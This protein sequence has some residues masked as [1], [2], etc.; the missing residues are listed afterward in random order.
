ME[1]Q[2]VL[3][4]D[5]RS[6]MKEIQSLY[7]DDALVVSNNKSRGRTEIIVAIDLAATSNDELGDLHYPAK[8]DVKI[9]KSI[10]N[11]SF[12]D[13]MEDKI[14]KS[15]KLSTPTS[16]V[17]A[18]NISSRDSHPQHLESNHQLDYLRSRE[19]LELVK[20]ELASIREEVRISQRLLRNDALSNISEQ[21]KDIIERLNVTG[22]PLPMRVLLSDMI[23]GHRDQETLIDTLSETIGRSIK[24]SDML[25]NLSGVHII[26]GPVGSGKSTMA[27]RIARQK[28]LDNGSTSV[29]IISFNDE[30]VGAWDQSQLLGLQAGVSIF[31]ARTAEMLKHLV[32]QLSDRELIII[33]TAG[34][35]LESQ[36]SLLQVALPLA[37]VHLLLPAD[38]SQ[39]LT[40]QYMNINSQ[41]WTSVMVSRLEDG[42][43]PWSVA[44]SLMNIDV[45]LSIASASNCPLEPAQPASGYALAAHGFKQ[46]VR[47]F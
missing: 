10:K 28:V 45:P 30:R 43:Y 25:S 29:A 34:S 36:L 13:V 26:S 17:T 47:G 32:E 1:L 20:S 37:K 18:T 6:A 33:D 15:S 4:K 38:A 41:P 21:S 14:F 2:R 7:G 16:L 5:T 12:G 39:A 8:Q 3:A 40:N 35:D 27:T 42:V 19:L 23:A 31:S 9:I 11:Q 46:L 24:V 44:N 22:M